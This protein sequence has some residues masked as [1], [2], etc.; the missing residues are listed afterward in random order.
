MANQELSA[1]DVQR[2]KQK[3]EEL[4]KTLSKLEEK[5]DSLDQEIW[6]KEMN[7]TRKHEKVLQFFHFPH[8]KIFKRRTTGLMV[9]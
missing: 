4:K 9:T 8:D 6:E 3:G 5:G 7:Y 2:M 1:A